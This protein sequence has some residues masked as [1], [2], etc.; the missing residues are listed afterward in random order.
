MGGVL[1]HPAFRFELICIIT[2]YGRIAIGSSDPNCDIGVI[3]Q[4]YF[5]DVFFPIN[6]FDWDSERKDYILSCPVRAMIGKLI[7]NALMWEKDARPC[8]SDEG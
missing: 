7:K 4:E 1:F 8:H 3:L 2:P 6:R 5:V